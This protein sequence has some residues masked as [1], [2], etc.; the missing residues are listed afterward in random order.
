MKRLFK[1]RLWLLL[2]IYIILDIIFTGMGMGVPIFNILLG[3]LAGFYI[4]R[5][6]L[7]Y[8][9]LRQAMFK[10]IV[11][12]LYFSLITLVIMAVIWGPAVKM[13]FA[14]N[15]DFKNFGIPMILYQPRASFIG[16]LVLMIII[17]PILQFIVSLSASYITITVY[18]GRNRKQ[19]S[20]F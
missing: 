5:R 13:L 18:L 10:S 8:F 2:I 14:S 7:L 15:A 16:W 4:T 12:S 9:E 3:F 19:T 20:I 17:S 6:N 11:Y 1:I